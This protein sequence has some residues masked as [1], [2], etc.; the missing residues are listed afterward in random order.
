[1]NKLSLNKL[2]VTLFRWT[3][4][5][6]PQEILSNI[7]KINPFGSYRSFKVILYLLEAFNFMIFYFFY[8]L[9]I[10]S[11]ISLILLSKKGYWFLI[12]IVLILLFGYCTYLTVKLARKK[13]FTPDNLVIFN[14][15]RIEIEENEEK[16]IEIFFD[17]STE[18]EKGFKR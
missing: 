16:I 12:Y 15:N 5:L 7:W 13:I 2:F 1:M 10:L 3:D 14:F 6:Q 11:I 18:L 9:A 8:I 4:K 17:L